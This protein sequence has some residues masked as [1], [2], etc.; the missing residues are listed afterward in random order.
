MYFHG[1]TAYFLLELDSSPL[2][3]Y[4]IASFSIHLMKDILSASKFWQL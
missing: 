3:E 1:Q 4:T 2:S